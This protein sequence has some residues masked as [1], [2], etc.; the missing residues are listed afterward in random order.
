LKAVEIQA[1]RSVAKISGQ[2]VASPRNQ[3]SRRTGRRVNNR[4]VP[5]FHSSHLKQRGQ[6]PLEIKVEGLLADIGP[7][8]DD[9]L[10][11]QCPGCLAGGVAGL[12]VTQGLL[13]FSDLLAVELRRVRQEAD[14]L[15]RRAWL[16]G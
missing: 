5:F 11:D 9:R 10:A 2:L 7:R 8:P 1:F 3:L 4:G 12:G 6:H 15:G 16:P 14:R 13:E